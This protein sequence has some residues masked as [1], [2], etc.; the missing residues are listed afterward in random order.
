MLQ[1]HVIGIKAEEAEYLAL[2]TKKQP[3]IEEKAKLNTSIA[4][5]KRKVQD[6]E[7]TSAEINGEVR[8]LRE[9]LNS[10]QA[11]IDEELAKENDEVFTETKQLLEEKE[12]EIVAQNKKLA[13]INEIKS[14]IAT[15]L[16]ELGQQLA[17]AKR[18]ET[19]L[20][21]SL[22]NDE[23]NLADAQAA[24]TDKLRA[25]GKT[26]PAAI[27]EI[28]AS[29]REFKYRPVGPIG[30]YVTLKDQKW[31]LP[32]NAIIGSNLGSFIATSHEDRILL[33]KI[34]R[35]HGCT[36]QIIV[37]SPS[38]IDYSRGT[39]DPSYLTALNVL[40]IGNELVKKALILMTGLERVVLSDDRPWAMNLIGVERPHNVDS[41]YTL[42][43]RI[44][45]TA[46]A[47]IATALYMQPGGNP[48]ESSKERIKILSRQIKENS[49]R[50]STC[51]RDMQRFQA[52]IATF[53]AENHK[54]RSD[55]GAI[56]RSVNLLKNE[57]RELEDR[58]G[59]SDKVA[60]AEYEKERV[61]IN[62][63]IDSYSSQ[64]ADTCEVLMS[65]GDAIK[66]VE[67][68]IAA[69]DHQISV[70]VA[71][72]EAAQDRIRGFSEEKRDI[73]SKLASSKVAIQ[74]AKAEITTYE[75]IVA[76][77]KEST[78]A[79][80][81]EATKLSER[82]QTR[83]SAT[84]IENEIMKLQEFIANNATSTVSYDELS[85]ELQHLISEFE[86][87]QAY[88]ELNTRL[89]ENFDRSLNNR[90]IAWTH[91]RS[92]IAG[93]SNSNFIG[94]IQSRNF[95][96]NLEYNHTEYTLSINIQVDNFDSDDEHV[97]KSDIKQLSGGEKSFGTTCFLVSLWSAMGCPFIC[98]DEFDVFMVGAKRR[99]PFANF[100]SFS[101]VGCCESSNG[102]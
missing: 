17:S 45:A 19:E 26:L 23:S 70:I 28:N 52:Q 74:S 86:R 38:P 3:I 48:F 57:C 63:Q 87:S 76:E 10:I 30:A 64:F 91:F 96:G 25:F 98:M 97:A 13:E 27:Q 60:L 15:E 20:K 16:N 51:Q 8:R 59:E 62:R 65:E 100:V 11:K 77:V 80:E 79:L 69:L 33:Q 47:T 14:Q 66:A 83:R 40:E 42:Q 84:S 31:A 29:S 95:R 78:F 12:N 58:L 54:L 22:D 61:I 94:S 90:K 4:A 101:F 18:M 50:L 85:A 1:E 71:E 44:T 89:L 81:V 37:I 82:I 68:Q 88:C 72:A 2:L 9:S 24:E 93:A 102:H 5:R 73:D 6:L 32:L 39:P 36:N 92:N 34:L 49:A 35:K 21:R 43:H 53:E 7:Q 41:A 55:H 67:D 56:T 46:N 99:I 75:R